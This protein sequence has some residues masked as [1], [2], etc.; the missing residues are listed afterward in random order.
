MG[1]TTLRQGWLSD[2]RTAVTAIGQR[3]LGKNLHT[4]GLPF[5]F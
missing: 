4:E 1:A 3:A 2:V 5:T